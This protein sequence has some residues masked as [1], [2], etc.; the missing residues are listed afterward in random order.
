MSGFEGHS[1]S[2]SCDSS[3][4]QSDIKRAIEGSPLAKTSGIVVVAVKNV[5]TISATAEKVDCAATA[6]LNSAQQAM[7]TYSF[8]NDPALGRGQYYVQ[9]KLDTD[10]FKPYP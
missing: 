1:G 7:M 4:G 6:I 10:T 3:H 8:T 5:K 2:P 9:A